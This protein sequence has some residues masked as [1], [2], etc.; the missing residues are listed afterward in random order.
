[1]DQPH[2]EVS[3]ATSDGSEVSLPQAYD[4]SN[5]SEL[6]NYHDEVLWLMNHDLSALDNTSVEQ[7]NQDFFGSFQPDIMFRWPTSAL[8]EQQQAHDAA[9]YQTSSVYD[10]VLLNS[11]FLSVAAG[12]V[13]DLAQGQGYTKESAQINGATSHIDGDP[14]A[15]MLR[16]LH[17]NYGPTQMPLGDER[18]SYAYSPTEPHQQSVENGSINAEVLSYDDLSLRMRTDNPVPSWRFAWE[19]FWDG[20]RKVAYLGPQGNPCGMT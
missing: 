5:S 20:V 16:V 19:N 9:G 3:F 4:Y 13:S 12:A 17:S 8:S 14:N 1:M 6:P 10:P 2:H 11:P 18:V 15:D 7:F